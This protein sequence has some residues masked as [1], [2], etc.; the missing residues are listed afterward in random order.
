MEGPRIAIDA[1]AARVR[2]DLG[3]GAAVEAI[4][5]SGKG[6]GWTR[7]R[8][9]VPV[10]GTAEANGRRWD[11]DGLAVDDVSA[12][13]HARHTRWHWSAGVGSAA[14]GR[15]V[16][17]NLVSGINDPPQHSERAVWVDGSPAEPAPV[18]FEGMEA[19]RFAAGGR[20]L[21]AAESERAR[22]DNMLLLRSRYRHCFGTFAGSLDGIELA[23]GYGVMEEHEALW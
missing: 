21:F 6:W 14:D 2:L 5:P 10:R 19:V 12:G 20:L 8:A 18:A 17:W 15:P 11:L 16:A 3:D 13:Y 9:G 23:V 4:C 7:K 22:D 1:G